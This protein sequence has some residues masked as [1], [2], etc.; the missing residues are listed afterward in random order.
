M[1]KSYEEI[2]LTPI[3]DSPSTMNM[4]GLWRAFR[5]VVDISRC[6]KCTLCWKFCP[7]TSI[8]I[9]DEFPVIDYDFCKGCGLCA[10]EC[11]FKCIAMVEEVK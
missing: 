6:K 11:P 2:P 9:E 10:E 7:D 1:T 4:T 5:P 8:Y 3:S